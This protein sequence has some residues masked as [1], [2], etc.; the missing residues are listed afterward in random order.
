M[1]ENEKYTARIPIVPDSLENRR[2]HKDKELV[3]DFTEDD[4]YIKRGDE[5][6][7]ITGEIREHVEQ[8]QDGSSVIHI[9]TEETLPPI[10]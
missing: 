1:A 3:M 5:Y 4:L 8:I 10:S 2:R 9:V 6:I 7:N